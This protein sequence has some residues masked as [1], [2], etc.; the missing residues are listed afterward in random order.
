M[1]IAS[2]V[3]EIWERSRGHHTTRYGAK[4][5]TR[6]APPAPPLFLI[7]L[8]F[9]T[10]FLFIFGL[11]LPS[12]MSYLLRHTTR[13]LHGCAVGWWWEAVMIAFGPTRKGGARR[14]PTHRAQF[15]FQ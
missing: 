1:A 10:F 9:I 8:W 14:P 6:T 4:H 3:A 13:T 2:V 12:L 7:F 15:Q 5:G 11:G